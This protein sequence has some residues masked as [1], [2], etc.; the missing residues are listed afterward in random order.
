VEW[1]DYALSQENPPIR[2]VLVLRIRGTRIDD[3]QKITTSRGWF[4]QAFAPV[5]TLLHVRNTG[6]LSHNE[7]ELRLLIDKW[8]WKDN[9]S[10]VP[11]I[12]E[13]GGDDPPLSWHLN[14]QEGC[15]RE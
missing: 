15:H 12:F 14:Q 3:D 8:K 7:I 9:V 11:A 6:Q 13:F 10:I 1:L 2:K 4:Y 5:A